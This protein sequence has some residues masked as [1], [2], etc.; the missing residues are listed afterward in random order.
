MHLMFLQNGK[1]DFESLNKRGEKVFGERFLGKVYACFS[2][3]MMHIYL[4]SFMYFIEYL[5]VY[6]YA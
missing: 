4:F 2:H 6:C 3:L 1:N 5:I